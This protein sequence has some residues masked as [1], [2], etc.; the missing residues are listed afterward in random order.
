MNNFTLSNLYDSNIKLNVEFS[1]TE[2]NNCYDILFTYK[3]PS[4]IN[5]L[6]KEIVFM[7]QLNLYDKILDTY[8][9]GDIIN[10]NPMTEQLINLMMLNDENLKTHS[11]HVTSECYRL[12]L[13]QI[14]K[15][16]WD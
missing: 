6:D 7:K 15:L 10:K 12:S 5:T 1:Y 11:G 13:I 3:F 9:E 16:L 14:I 8:Y 4:E 2:K